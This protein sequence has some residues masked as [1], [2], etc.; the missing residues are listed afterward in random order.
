MIRTLKPGEFNEAIDLSEYAFRYKLS[1]EKRE[2]RLSRMNADEIFGYFNDEGKLM[3]KLHLL[4]FKMY[5][6]GN[7]MPMG[8]VAGVATWPEFRRS[9]HVK[10]LLYHALKAM[11]ENGQAISMLH[12]FSVKFY[13]KYGWE[14]TCDYKKYEI[15]KEQFPQTV[16][17]K[18]KVGRI[19]KKDVEMLHA[20]YEQFA[21]V[22]NGSLKRSDV[23]WERLI[24]DENIV[25]YKNEENEPTG[26]L[27]YSIK[28]K[29][30]KID[31]FVYLDF[32]SWNG[33]WRFIGNHDSMIDLVTMIVPVDD[34]TGYYLS[35]PK[36]KQEQYAYFMGRIVDVKNVLEQYPFDC[37]EDR[38]LFLHVHDEFAEWNAGTYLVSVKEG[39][40]EITSFNKQKEQAF[41]THPPKKGVLC[42]IQSLTAVLFNYKKPSELY[43]F[44]RISGNE[45]DIEHFEK[46]IPD[47]TPFIY[48][49]F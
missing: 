30:F 14:C 20:V 44:G 37:S 5:L 9:G 23:W 16:T 48:D 45:Q 12:P 8:G 2:E 4:S 32:M 3:A 25:V 18:G 27:I 40:K 29:T 7:V 10:G 49:F 41:C 33:L 43:R 38:H 13:R 46:M 19:T 24:D 35:D 21:K 31:E 42:D 22:Y 39:R 47:Y 15:K 17:V 26:Y 6:G 28:E 34:Q 11:K 36:I 1:E